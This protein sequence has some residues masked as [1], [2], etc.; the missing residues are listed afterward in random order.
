MF[1]LV[2]NNYIINFDNNEHDE[3]RIICL[4]YGEIDCRCHIQRQINLN[5]NEDDI[6]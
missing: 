4:N 3:N 1:G 5:R 2:K 6:I